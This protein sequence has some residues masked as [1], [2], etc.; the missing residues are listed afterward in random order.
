MNKTAT[1]VCPRCQRT[2]RQDFAAQHGHEVHVACQCRGQGNRNLVEYRR[3]DATVVA[4]ARGLVG[5][6]R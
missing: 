6:V 5:S 1:H 4:S 2:T 3:V